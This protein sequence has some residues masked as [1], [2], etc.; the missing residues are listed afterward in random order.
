MLPIGILIKLIPSALETYEDKKQ[1]LLLIIFT[2]IVFNCPLLLCSLLAGKLRPATCALY[3]VVRSMVVSLTYMLYAFH[4]NLHQYLIFCN[5]L[6]CT[7]KLGLTR[8]RV[9]P[10]TRYATVTGTVNLSLW[11]LFIC[12]IG[13][14]CRV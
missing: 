13:R 14:K 6:Y 5:S 2:Q 12:R 10:G 8:Y 3:G 4:S 1:V 11:V 9:L 7:V